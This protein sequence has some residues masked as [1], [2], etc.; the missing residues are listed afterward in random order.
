MTGR[1]IGRHIGGGRE[2]ED[3]RVRR[4][5][6]EALR[7]VWSRWTSGVTLLA[8][9]AE[10]RV[11]ALTVGSF[12]PV[13]LDPP[14]VLASL[15][16]NAAALPYLDPG[17]VFGISILAGDQRALAS[18]Y[19]DPFPVGPDPFPEEGPPITA[20]ALATMTCVVEE[21]LERG[22]H[23]LV[24]GRVDEV[25]TG[26]EGAALAYFRRSYHAIG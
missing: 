26:E 2:P 23:T 7:E 13:S 10:G 18:R 16:P 9:R 12:F 19:A 15:G 6:Q 5:R 4:E 20:G 3:E 24:I 11:H 8:T 22:D 25:S 14:L 17:S 21:L 1:R